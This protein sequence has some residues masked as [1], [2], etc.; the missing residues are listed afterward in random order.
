MKKFAF[1]LLTVAAVLTFFQVYNEADD[2]SVFAN[3]ETNTII[4]SGVGEVSRE[5]DIAY[6]Q[7]GVQAV[8]ETANAAQKEV[9]EKIAAIKKVAKQFNLG[10]KDVRTAYFHVF[11][12]E[13]FNANGETTVEKYR[14]EH[15]LEFTVTDLNRLGEFIDAAAK[16]GANRVDQVRFGLKNREDAEHE[17][18]KIAIERAKRKADVIAESAGKKLGDVI[19]IADQKAQIEI[20][21][22]GQFYQHVETIDSTTSSAIETGEVHVTQR[23]DVVFRMND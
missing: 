21:Y 5:P 7:L 23:V 18:L 3:S 1:V 4:A 12:Y 10:D 19:Q 6:V 22:A 15:A 13:Q 8:N 17:A 9:A 20:P 14:A 2:A 16:A 11:P